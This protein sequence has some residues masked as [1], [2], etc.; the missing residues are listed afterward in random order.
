MSFDFLW[1]NLLWVIV[2]VVATR[3][4]TFLRTR[5]R[6]RRVRAL[7]GDDALG[8]AGIAVTVPIL[9]PLTRDPFDK[10]PE[11]TVGLKT[12]RRR[13]TT[14]WPIYGRVMHLDDYAAAEEIFSLLR[15]Q[16]VTRYQLVPDSDS[17]GRWDTNPCVLC[18]GS[19]FVNA[20]FSELINLAIG[21]GGP[22]ITADRATDTLDSYRVR[23]GGHEPMAFGV[24]DALAIGVI[25][26][27]AN[28]TRPQDS[29]VGV[30]GCRSE[31]TLATAHYLRSEFKSV[32]GRI[33]HGKP[34]VMLLAVRGAGLNVCK[35]ML[36]VTDRVLFR[37]P[38]LLALYQRPDAPVVVSPAD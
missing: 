13:D 34:L 3:A 10:S 20:T 38:E 26:R 19:P 31:S 36:A 8:P 11:R 32:V 2:G 22:L 37:S 4:W 24:T 27:L 21:P 7:L 15:E 1:Q 6:H 29:A 25:A 23:L 35:P 28:P 33:E 12:S 5:L 17:L 9:D 18:L 30:W 16:G 14:K